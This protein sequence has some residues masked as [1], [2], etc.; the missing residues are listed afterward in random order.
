MTVGSIRNHLAAH[1]EFI[2]QQKLNREGCA[3]D[4][5]L[6][7]DLPIEWLTDLPAEWRHLPPEQ[8]ATWQ[9]VLLGR[10]A[11]RADLLLPS[12]SKGPANLKN[13]LSVVRQGGQ[14]SFA[15]GPVSGQLCDMRVL[16]DHSFPFALAHGGFQIQ[17]EQTATAL[18]AVG[19]EVEFVRWWDDAQH[20]DLIHFFGRPGED[21]IQQAQAKGLRVVMS[22]LLTALGSRSSTARLVQKN[23]I[24]V[25]RRVM[26]ASF[27]VRMAWNAYRMADAIIA[28]TP[29]EARLMQEMFGAPADKIHVVANGVEEVFL[30]SPP[31]PRG[32]WLVCTATITERKRVLELAEA[33][34]AVRTP[35]WI[36]GQ[37]YS[38]ADGYA[39]R[40]EQLARA[41]PQWVRYEGP[42][43][44]RAR[45]AQ[46]YREARGFVLLSA[47]ESLSL[48]ALEA[49]ACGCP[50]LLSDLPWAR[51]VFGD[52]AHYVPVVSNTA[53]TAA[54]LRSFY[55]QAPGLPVPPPPK[56]WGEIAEQ[57]RV[58]YERLP[59]SS[60]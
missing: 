42:I 14:P 24:E 38:Q 36:I 12:L 51:T 25:V 53:R 26:P 22:E 21:Y 9:L 18:R 28:L 52:S 20:G 40:F 29:W 6:V 39:D 13:K 8:P 46:V 1:A 49:A 43:K 2:A 57:L 11:R 56:T 37:P 59:S 44:D 27:T 30:H 48:S 3:T 50:L 23:L 5:R 41:N 17:I 31:S 4:R 54:A 55:E 16:F 10:F 32:N 19:V 15:P 60:R 33:A 34:V 45:L 58:I 47:M 7:S 35:T